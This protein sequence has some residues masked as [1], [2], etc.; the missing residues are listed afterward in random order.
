MVTA[1]NSPRTL[2]SGDAPSLNKMGG[3]QCRLPFLSPTIRNLATRYWFYAALPG[4]FASRVFS[5]PTLTL[6]C[7]GLASAFLANLIF[8]TPLS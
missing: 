2:R 3:V 7:L 4:A 1:Y 5:R 8:S 6:F